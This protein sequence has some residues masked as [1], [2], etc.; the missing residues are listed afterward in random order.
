MANYNTQFSEEI[1]D[2]TDAERE[3]IRNFLRD[4]Y[5]LDE[6]EFDRWVLTAAEQ[7][8]IREPELWPCFG[9]EID[10]RELWIHSDDGDDLE[11]V[12]IFVQEFFKA[13]RPDAVWSLEWASTCSRPWIGAFGGG[14]VVV[15]ATRQEWANTGSQRAKLTQIVEEGK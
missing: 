4:P 3:W 7:L 6:D 13:Y 15:S 5:D 8:N 14:C 2:L 10:G 11:N 1:T 12:V 9:W